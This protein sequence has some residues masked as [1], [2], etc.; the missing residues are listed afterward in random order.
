MNYVTL[1]QDA[2]PNTSGYMIAGYAVF[3]VVMAVYLVSF[4][5]RRRN[6]EQDLSTLHTMEEEIKQKAATPLPQRRSP[7]KA[8]PTRAVPPKRS[9][10]KAAAAKTGTKRGGTARKRPARRSR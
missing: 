5:A 1:L 2:T 8:A 7:R 10:R 3:V 4:L 6:L 9:P